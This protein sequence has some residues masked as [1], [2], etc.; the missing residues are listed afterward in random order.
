MINGSEVAVIGMAGRFPGAATIPQF[1]ENLRNGTESIRF[2]SDEEL[3]TAG[4]DPRLLEQPN[5]VKAKAYLE[6]ADCFDAIFFG[7]S[8]REAEIMDPQHRVFLEA[9]YHAL[10]DAGYASEKYKGAIGIYA[11]ADTNTYLLNN[12]LSHPHLL[13]SVGGL[14]LLISNEKTYAHP[15][16]V[17]A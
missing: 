8:P 7:Y 10:E 5:Y 16:L 4:V 3:L 15:S 12:L 1:W 9:A 14:Q 6:E 17:Q 13:A 11:G 2:F